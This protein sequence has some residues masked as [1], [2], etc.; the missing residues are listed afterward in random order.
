M[1]EGKRNATHCFGGGTGFANAASAMHAI[2]SRI[3][4]VG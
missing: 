3:A 4:T 2:A 1:R